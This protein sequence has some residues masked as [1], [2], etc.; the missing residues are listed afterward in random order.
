MSRDEAADAGVALNHHQAVR[1]VAGVWNETPWNADPDKSFF[2]AATGYL[3]S[4]DP[5][6]PRRLIRLFLPSTLCHC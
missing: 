3:I 2:T 5:L 6:P 1:R 4:L